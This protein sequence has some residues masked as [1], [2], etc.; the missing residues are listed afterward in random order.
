MERLAVGTATALAALHG[1]AVVHRD[2]TPG[3][4]LLGADGP[5]VIDVG[6]SR[7]LDSL[8]VTGH[9]AGI[10]A[11]M[12][13]EQL[14]GTRVGAPADVFAWG[15]TM[16]FAATGSPP[17]GEDSAPEVMRRMLHEEPDLRGL[18]GSLR[19]AVAHALSKDPSHRPTAARLLDRLLRLPGLPDR[20]IAM[21]VEALAGA[22]SAA[23]TTEILRPRSETLV[24]RN[25][26]GQHAFRG[27]EQF[28]AEAPDRAYVPGFAPQHDGP[29]PAGGRD[30]HTMG[31]VA[32]V[33]L[34]ILVGVAVITLVL[35]PRL[36]G[37]DGKRGTSARS[38]PS[39]GPVDSVPAAYGGTWHGTATNQRGMRFVV[40]VTFRAGRRTAEVRYPPPI[41]CDG[42]LTLTR[43]VQ[44]RLDMS[45]K[46]PRPC[47]DGGVVTVTRQAD[48]SLLYAW[49]K[50]KTHLSY[51]ATLRSG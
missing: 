3:N 8:G 36:S 10:P 43:G 24:L 48:G 14:T 33:A 34:G 28:A 27:P 16:A 22:A 13:P 45:L 2:L 26:T 38:T 11:F 51:R 49:M 12:A 39:D 37:D 23:P 5:C 30:G 35:W 4:V 46:V 19:D 15:L 40:Q 7:A 41:G 18:P 20:V 44:S 6:V 32:S 25:T 50:P 21:A 17:F 9:G 42:T 29:A 31:I 1:A 47:T